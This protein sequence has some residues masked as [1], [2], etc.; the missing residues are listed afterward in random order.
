MTDNLTAAPRWPVDAPQHRF[1]S[2]DYREQ[3]D[4]DALAAALRDLTDGGL[5]VVAIDTG[6]QDYAIALSTVPLTAD[7][8]RELWEASDE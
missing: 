7:E 1:L 6:G 5:H 4:L 2:W 3:P 8:A